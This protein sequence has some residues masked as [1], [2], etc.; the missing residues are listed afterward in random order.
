MNEQGRLADEQERFVVDRRT[1]HRSSPRA[2]STSWR[3]PRAPTSPGCASSSRATA[4]ALR[5]PPRA[6]PGRRLRAAPR[7]RRRAAHRP[8]PRPARRA[9]ASRSATPRWKAPRSRCARPRAAAA[10]EETVTRIEHVRLETHP[11]FF[12]IFVDGCQF[13]PLR[14]RRRE[15]AAPL[16]EPAARGGRRPRSRR[17]V[18]APARLSRAR[19]RE[20][21]LAERAQAARAWYAAHGRPWIGGAARR[22]SRGSDADSVVLA[23]GPVVREPRRWPS[24][25]ARRSR[26]ASSRWPSPPAP[27]W[28]RSTRRHWTEGRPDEGVLPRPPRRARSPSSSCAA[29]RCG[30]CRDR[31]RRAGETV[32]AHAEPRAAA[33]GTRGA[34]QADGRADGGRRRRASARSGC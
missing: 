10:L 8:D 18:R 3:R 34:D 30:S 2:T 24:A 1:A 26:T 12:D 23:T 9:P 16:V 32:L 31:R 33:A 22:R 14:G 17:G 11:R 5:R 28:T 21:T 6:L 4:S 27:R 25:C 19:L 29:R 15:R 7:P 13:A 20:A